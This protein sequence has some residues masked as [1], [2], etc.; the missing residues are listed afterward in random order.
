MDAYKWYAT[1]ADTWLA[2]SDWQSPGRLADG[3]SSHFVDARMTILIEEEFVPDKPA[4]TRSPQLVISGS[5]PALAGLPGRVRAAYAVAGI[6][7]VQS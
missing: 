3:Y 2:V 6:E 5:A 4:L 7:R 1:R